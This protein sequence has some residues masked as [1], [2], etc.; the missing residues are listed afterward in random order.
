MTKRILMTIIMAMSAILLVSCGGSETQEASL[1]N[2]EGEIL[3]DIESTLDDLGIDYTIQYVTDPD[4][5]EGSFISYGNDH[6]VGDVVL[7]NESV[8]VIVST[9]DLYLPDLSGMEQ[10]DIF[11]FL[12]SKGFS[13]NSYDFE[14][15]VNNDVDDMTFY[16]YKNHDIGDQIDDSEEFIILIAD[17]QESLPDLT[18]KLETEIKDILDEQQIK[19]TFSE[20]ENDDYAEGSFAYYQGFDIGDYYEED[21]TIEVVLYKNSFT[22]TDLGLFISKYIDSEDNS[23]IELYNPTDDDI[24][25]EDYHLVIYANGSYDVTSRIEFEADSVIAAK[26]TFLITSTNTDASLQKIADLRSADFVFD[27]ND[28][29]QLRYKN[30][31]YIDTVYNLGERG[32]IMDNEIYVR[33]DTVS[34]GNRDYSLSEWTAFVPDYYEIIG[35]HPLD[36]DDLLT[37]TPAEVSALLIKGF[38]HSEGGMA[39]VE[40]R[41]IHD[42]DTAAFYPGFMGDERVRFLGINTPETSPTVAPDGPE[43]WG[44]EAKAYTTTILEYADTNDLPIYIQS[45]PDLGYSETYGR[46]LGLV[47]V[48]LGDNVLSI[49]I[50]DSEE[51]V[52]F[53]EEL[54]GL[55]LVNYHV[56]KNGFSYN[57]YGS[58]SNL[59]INNRY[60]I[61]W[62]QE[63]EKFARDNNLGIHE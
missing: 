5:D 23:A 63:A 2:L 17:N 8:I 29:I 31:T 40:V 56:V 42:G 15:I 45:D 7:E 44:L 24:N 43:P 58:E 9:E 41:D 20:V 10:F 32:F 36:I 13:M 55:I 62:L 35:T 4:L 54:T 47:W 38:D 60:M 3:S 11:N 34:S 46:H 33:R 16:G 61:R 28:T 18:G 51:N 53:T 25:L 22:D 52:L 37:L 19:F 27:G 14:I 12:S 49:D 48:D 1:P 39:E 26:D 6:Q 30:D 50:L 59:V 57:Y 21:S